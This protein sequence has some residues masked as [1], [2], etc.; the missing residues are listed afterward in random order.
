[1]TSGAQ[2]ERGSPLGSNDARTRSAGAWLRGELRK[3][4][5]FR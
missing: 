4:A 3:S 5:R 1:M 2:I